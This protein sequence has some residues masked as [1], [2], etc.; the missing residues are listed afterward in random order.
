[1]AWCRTASSV[2]GRGCGWTRACERREPSVFSVSTTSFHDISSTTSLSCVPRRSRFFALAPRLLRLRRTRRGRDRRRYAVQ[3]L[4][5]VDAALREATSRF[6]PRTESISDRPRAVRGAP[7]ARARPAR[8]AASGL[9]DGVSGRG[10]LRALPPVDDPVRQ[11]R[12]HAARRSRPSVLLDAQPVVGADGWRH[13]GEGDRDQSGAGRAPHHH[14]VAAA[15]HDEHGGLEAGQRP[16]RDGV[17]A[18]QATRI[19]RGLPQPPDRVEEAP[20]RRADHGRPRRQHSAG[21]RPPVRRRHVSRSRRGSDRVDQG[22]SWPHPEPSPQGLGTGP[23]GAGE[24]LS[25]PVRRG[26]RSVEGDLRRGRVGG[27]SRVLSDGAGRQPVLRARDGAPVPGELAEDARGEVGYISEEAGRAS[28]AA[29]SFAHSS[30]VWHAPL[31]ELEPVM[32]DAPRTTAPELAALADEFDIV[33][34]LGGGPRTPFLIATRKS[35]STGR[36]GDSDRVL[37]EVVRPPEGDE[38]HALDHLASDTKLLSGQRHRRFVSILGG[39]WLGDDAFAI[40]R[41]Y[42]DDPSVADLL[43]RGDVF[44]NTRT[45]A[46]LREVHGLLQWARNQNIVH[47]RVTTDRLFLEPTSDRV[48]VSFVVGPLQRVRKTDAASEDVITVVRLAVAMLTGGITAEEADGQSFAELR[49][50]LPDRL[51]EETERLLSE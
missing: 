8:H 40:V 41:E 48:R 45:A 37:I 3:Q 19:V 22:P 44:T 30:P 26:D 13:H 16:T 23:G 20:R 46:I 15:E 6:S 9:A 32:P 28:E 4:A 43:A 51:F 29:A 1:M 14:G 17:R 49:P 21:V 10:V 35:T 39:K 42:V 50:D 7:G 18:A 34:E 12:A 31:D 33:G 47:R 36:R 27:R 5:S 38:S 11:G 24:G 25:R 2:R